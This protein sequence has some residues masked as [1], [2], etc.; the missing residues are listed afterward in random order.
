MKNRLKSK[1]AIILGI[2]LALSAIITLKSSVYL[3]PDNLIEM[4]RNNAVPG[5]IALGMLLVII[6]GGIDVSIGAIV[7]TVTVI[8]G[9]S[10]VHLGL[11]TPGAFIL[12]ALA[13]ALL[14]SANGLLVAYLNIPPIVATLGTMSILNGLILYHTDG[15]WVNDLPPP[16]IEFGNLSYLEIIPDGYGGHT[17]IPVQ[18]IILLAALGLTHIVLRHTVIG[19]GIYAL[20]GHARSAERVGYNLKKIRMFTY[21]YAGLLAGVAAIVHTTIARQVDPNAFTGAELQVIA[22]VVLGGANILGGAGSVSG[23]LLGVLLLAVINNGLVLAYIPV[24]WQ[25]IIIGAIIILTVSIDIW[26]RKQQE[27]RL[28]KVDIDPDPEPDPAPGRD[29]TPEP[30]PHA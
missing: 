29:P 30:E 21:A 16:F 7:A 25:K 5:L 27:K 10:M 19:R 28:T 24:F 9:Q 11:D 15:A 22:A 18:F 3:R 23:T 14:G 2:I 20:G 17:G 12:G 13:G 6:T 4:L 26:R 8:V 1:E